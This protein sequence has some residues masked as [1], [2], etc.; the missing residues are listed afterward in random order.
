MPTCMG[1]MYT[2]HSAVKA[3]LETPSPSGKHARWWSKVDG[4]G[5]RSLHITYHAGKDNTNADALSRNPQ[6]PA[7]AK[8]TANTEVQVAAVNCANSVFFLL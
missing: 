2:D 3:I 5:V 7:P 6:L 4:S 1:M 8:D